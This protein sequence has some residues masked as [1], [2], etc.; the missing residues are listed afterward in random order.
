[1]L[2]AATATAL[3]QTGVTVEVIVVDDASPDGTFEAAQELAAGDNRISALRLDVNGG[4]GAARN[5][6]FDVAR[7]DWIAV[8]DADDLMRSARLADMIALARQHAADVVLGNL[9]E[10][11]VDGRP[12]G[13][14]P[15]LTKP[16]VPTRWDIETFVAGNMAAT[17][18]RSYGY[19]KP[20]LRRAFVEAHALRYDPTLRNGEDF[21]LILSC[22]AAGARV[23]FSPDPA[24]LYTRRAGSLSHRSEPA[25]IT[26]LL[27][28]D[29][30]FVARHPCS[31]GLRQMMRDRQRALADVH[32]AEV[33][34][35]AVRRARIGAAAAA[36]ARRPQ[37]TGRILRQLGE[38]V[39]KR[40]M[41]RWRAEKRLQ[42]P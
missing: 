31:P 16:T 8:L 7:G 29:A 12:T 21:H 38:A 1:M 37:A 32:T 4:P 42:V 27:A 34:L 14:A 3:A 35:G 6:A 9:T 5:R 24:Y 10:V 11:C 18:R 15:F 23:W 41:R 17:G 25:H 40:I 39:Q 22:Y 19:L 33:V 28:A 26:A 36:V 2:R 20:L 13:D 30:A